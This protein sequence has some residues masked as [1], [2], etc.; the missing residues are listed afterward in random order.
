MEEYIK[1]AVQLY[2]LGLITCDELSGIIAKEY[3]KLI[4]RGKL[5]NQLGLT[6]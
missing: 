3:T 2:I 1:K 6:K 5:I 4:I